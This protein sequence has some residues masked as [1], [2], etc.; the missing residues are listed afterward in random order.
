MHSLRD[1]Y[2]ALHGV[3]IDLLHQMLGAIIDLL[4][5]DPDQKAFARREV[6]GVPDRIG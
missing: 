6:V 5:V 3:R 4:G 2:E 1:K